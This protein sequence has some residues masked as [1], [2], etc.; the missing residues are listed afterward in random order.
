MYE[1]LSMARRWANAINTAF[2]LC[3]L[4]LLLCLLVIISVIKRESLFN[5][6]DI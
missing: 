3:M 2:S 6:F 5:E 1:M 4:F